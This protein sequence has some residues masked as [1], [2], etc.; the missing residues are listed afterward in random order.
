MGD[1]SHPDIC[2][3]DH[4]ARH[5][6]SGRFLQ[7]T[8]DNF[9]MQVVEE[10]T[11]RGVLLDLALTNKGLVEDVKVGGSLGCSDHEMVEF[12]M[13]R[14]R[15]KAIS[16]ITALDFRRANFGLFEDLLGGILW[17]RALEDR[18]VQESSS[19]FKHHFLH[20]QEWCIPL[21]KKSS[22]RGRRPVW[23]SKELLAELIWKKK[24]YGMWKEGQATWE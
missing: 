11:R 6:Q 22:K 13:L 20:A 3:E 4:T 9:L 23:M 16:R 12:K 18:G 15:S 17:V 14:G 24:V 10:P 19:P 5:T 1:F 21:S 7:S 8:D 2:W